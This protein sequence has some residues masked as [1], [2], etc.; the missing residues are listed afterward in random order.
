[1][2]AGQASAGVEVGQRNSL[3]DIP[4][5]QATGWAHTW[6]TRG[7]RR[8]PRKS[9]VSDRSVWV[10]AGAT[11]RDGETPA[12]VGLREEVRVLFW[13]NRNCSKPAL[14]SQ[15]TC[16]GWYEP[17]FMG[18]PRSSRCRPE[19]SAQEIRGQSSSKQGSGLT[20]RREWDI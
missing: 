2:V 16:K 19:R 4:E 17:G 11:G 3:R 6:G 5:A 9:G 1:M 20:L 8:E 13:N 14:Y 10:S 12:M 15:C 18:L 7:G